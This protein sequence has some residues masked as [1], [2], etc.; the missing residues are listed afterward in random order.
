[1]KFIEALEHATFIIPQNNGVD[2]FGVEILSDGYYRVVSFDSN[3]K[4]IFIRDES[5]DEEFIL[6]I[7]H[8]CVADC[9]ILTLEPLEYED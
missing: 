1:M 4:I 8:P 2:D 5:T 6:D 7:D 9:K 3:E